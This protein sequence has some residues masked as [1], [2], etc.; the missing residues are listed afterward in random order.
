MAESTV[1]S[2]KNLE[3]L[4]NSI[5]EGIHAVDLTGRTIVYNSFSAQLDGMRI[6]EVMGKHILK[7]FPSLTNKTSTLLQ[8]IKTG[9]PVYHHQQSY[10]NMHG[11]KIDSVNT[12]LPIKLDGEMIAAVEVAKDYSRIRQLTE[13]VMELEN[14]RNRKPTK[15]TA[16]HTAT[17]V[18]EDL[19]SN[20]PAFLQEVERGRKAACSASP[21]LLYGESGTGK[22]LFVHGI[23]NASSR[24][25]G[26]FIAQNC[27]ALP[28]SLLES[29]LFGTAKGS[30]TGAV[31]RKGLF[32]LADGGTLFLDEIQSMSMGIQ[33]KLL[34]VLEDG[35]IR[36]VGGTNDKQVDVRVISAMNIDPEKAMEEK[37]LRPDLYFRLNV[38]SF[39]LP[40][41]RERPGDISLL[42]VHFMEFFN[43]RLNKRF[44]TVSPLV[45]ETMKQ[46]RWP[47]NVRELKHCIEFMAIHSEGT[48]LEE[49]PPFLKNKKVPSCLP[50]I[51]SLRQALMDKETEL[52]EMAMERTNGNVL[53][54][55]K[56]LGIPRQTLQ[57][58]MKK[59]GFN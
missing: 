56:L 38:L 28:E 19:K 53:Q 5:D 29:L 18:F 16:S 17:Y 50:E 23:H 31:D 39:C 6:D 35:I 42:T 49:L 51:P 48:L 34:R 52:V 41:L 14:K 58:K 2:Q 3:L 57:Y 46:Y 12:T 30:Y 32:E 7:A 33:A 40:P 26:P 22:E 20:D 8:V 36:R 27:A 21:V 37:S 45:M 11:R 55:A 59:P 25:S 15:K 54:A 24:A 47:G 10:L 4:L 44:S 43:R 13:R 9:K 1:F